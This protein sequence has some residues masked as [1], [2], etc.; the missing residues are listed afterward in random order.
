MDVHKSSLWQ[1]LIQSRGWRF[2][3]FNANTSGAKNSNGFRYGRTLKEDSS[4]HL[5]GGRTRQIT[6]SARWC[7]TK[8][9]HRQ[10]TLLSGGGHTFAGLKGVECLNGIAARFLETANPKSLDVACVADIR[11]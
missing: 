6:F 11:R 4:R 2:R 10:F 3:S 8:S 7:L 5:R 9:K 1:F